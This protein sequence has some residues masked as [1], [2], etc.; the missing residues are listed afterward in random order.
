MLGSTSLDEEHND[1]VEELPLDFILSVES[2]M[3]VQRL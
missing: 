2:Q 1:D 3:I